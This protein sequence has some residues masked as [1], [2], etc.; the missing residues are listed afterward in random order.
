V[1]FSA[2]KVSTLFTQ[3]KQQ[4][5]ATLIGISRESEKMQ[6]HVNPDLSAELFS[7]DKIFYI[8]ERRIKDIQWQKFAEDEH[9]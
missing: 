3:L 7:G 9:V 1:S 2:I 5:K 6:I 4:Y 8:A